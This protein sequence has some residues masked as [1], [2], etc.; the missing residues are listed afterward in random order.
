MIIKIV[1]AYLLLINIVTFIFYFRDKKKS[2]RGQWRTKE[3]TLILLSY[4]GG[5][6]GALLGMYI[7]R[8]KTQHLKF[9]ILIPLS[10]IL[11]LYI[12]YYTL[13]KLQVI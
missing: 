8:H 9:R 12:L 5:F 4:L 7:L 11:W 2:I 3:F 10:A 6:V 13:S 1:C